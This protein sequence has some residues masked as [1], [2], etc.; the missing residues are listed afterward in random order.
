MTVACPA[1]S[2]ANKDGAPRCAKCGGGVFDC[3]PGALLAGRYAFGPPIGQGRRG[4]VYQV[5]D[6]AQV[7]RVALRVFLPPRSEAPEY[8]DDFRSEMARLRTVRHPHVCALHEH[9]E[10]SGV[11]YLVMDRVDG[12]SL[13]LA[14]KE[15]RPTARE[16]GVLSFQMAS[17]LAAIHEAGVVHRVLNSS[18]VLLDAGGAVLVD[19]GAYGLYRA[20]PGMPNVLGNPLG[21]FEYVAPEGAKTPASDLYALGILVFE[22]FTGA[23]PFQSPSFHSILFMH[24]KEDPLARPEAAGLP[25]GVRPLLARLLAKSPEDRPPSARAVAEELRSLI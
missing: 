21:P 15:R 11:H 14:L 24:M 22:L 19:Q 25:A 4:I 23:V 17:G 18:N 12:R 13:E 8:L 16:A 5:L 10:Q 2:H 9:G 3:A 1:C 7:R 20:L 6:R